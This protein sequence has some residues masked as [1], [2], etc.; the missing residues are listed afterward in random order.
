MLRT[1]V[2]TF[3][4]CFVFAFIFTGSAQTPSFDQLARLYNYDKNTPFNLDQKEVDDRNGINI[5]LATF[6]VS[7]EDRAT[8]ILIVPKSAGRHPGIIWMHSSGPFFWFSDAMLMAQA[9][10]MS[11][12]VAPNFGSPDLPAEMYRD[13]MIGAVIIIRRSIDIL[14]SRS[15]V[16]PQRIGYVGHSFGALMGAVA[17][18]VDKRFKAAVF[19]VGLPGMSYHL[20]ASPV[21]WA[22][23]HRQNLGAGLNDYLKVI[24][25]VDAIHYI[26]RTSPTALLFQSAR[27]DPG[28]SEQEALEFF[29]AA[30]EPKEL[31]WYDAVHEVTDIAAVCDRARFLAKELKLPPI[32]PLLRK[33]AGLEERLRKKRK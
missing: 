5:Y 9:G 10:A 24:S 12:I 17:T 16:D 20:R 26:G 4:T 29:R 23:N 15:D 33:K 13:A 6:T 14:E 30:G 18:A 22:N 27:L 3:L 25:V 19:E 31:K 8:C 21:Q 7:K 1:Q 28:V 2:F 32:D 11:L